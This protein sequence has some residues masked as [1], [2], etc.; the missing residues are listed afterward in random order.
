MLFFLEF[1]NT[2]F[3]KTVITVETVGRDI[4][5]F[6]CLMRGMHVA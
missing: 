3:L 2:V 1:V 5:M 4:S 6:M